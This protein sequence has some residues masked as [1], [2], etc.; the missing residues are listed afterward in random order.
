MQRE[1]PGICT[2]CGYAICD[3]VGVHDRCKPDEEEDEIDDEPEEF[4]NEEQLP[5][6]ST[7][8]ECGCPACSSPMM[9]E[10]DGR[11]IECFHHDC[12]YYSKFGVKCQ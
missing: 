12:N 8:L 9:D 11:C 6:R 4:V 10:L 3:G 1:K 5:Q 2:V 7:P